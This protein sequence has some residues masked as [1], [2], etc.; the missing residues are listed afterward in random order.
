MALAILGQG[1]QAFSS[2]KSSRFQRATKEAG[3]PGRPYRPWVIFSRRSRS[4]WGPP[5]PD[6]SSTR[7]SA[8]SKS[9]TLPPLAVIR[10]VCKARMVFPLLNCPA[11]RARPPFGRTPP[12]ITSARGGRSLCSNSAA[13]MVV[14]AFAGSL[15]VSVGFAWVSRLTSRLGASWGP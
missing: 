3:R 14:I 7:P 15:T 11:R 4:S 5:S 12:P 1:R 6:S 2:A 13:V 9:R 10:A 8:V